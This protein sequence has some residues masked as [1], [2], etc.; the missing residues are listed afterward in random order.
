MSVIMTDAVTEQEDSSLLPA[1]A[2]VTPHSAFRQLHQLHQTHFK[3]V[4]IEKKLETDFRLVGSESLFLHIAV[5]AV[6]ML[7]QET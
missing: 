3:Y 5:S 6:P 7:L 2:P 4:H 1:A